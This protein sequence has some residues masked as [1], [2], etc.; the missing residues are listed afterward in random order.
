MRPDM[1][2]SL[3]QTRKRASALLHAGRHRSAA[4]LAAAIEAARRA[5]IIAC[6]EAGVPF[7]S[8]IAALDAAVAMSRSRS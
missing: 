1:T 6:D 7:D 4:D 2:H 8:L 5:L 3:D